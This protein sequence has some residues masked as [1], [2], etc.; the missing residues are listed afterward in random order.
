MS[1]ALF[2]IGVTL[3]GISSFGTIIK[4][5]YDGDFFLLNL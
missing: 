4:S 5:I 1:Y 2:I 3:T